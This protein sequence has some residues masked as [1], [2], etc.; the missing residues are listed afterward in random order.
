MT[1]S[2]RYLLIGGP[3]GRRLSAES[4]SQL[5]VRIPKLVSLGSYPHTRHILIFSRFGTNF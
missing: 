3:G 1:F 5:L 2:T 4:V